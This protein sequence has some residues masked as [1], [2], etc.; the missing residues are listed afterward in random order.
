MYEALCW[1]ALLE[2]AGKQKTCLFNWF[3]KY[4]QP[5]NCMLFYWYT[6]T[7]EVRFHRSNPFWTLRKKK[8]IETRRWV[9]NTWLLWG[10]H[11]Y[12]YSQVSA[13]QYLVFSILEKKK[14]KSETSLYPLLCTK[15]IP[16]VM[17]GTSKVGKMLYW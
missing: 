3:C 1:C 8:K 16:A 6:L 2:T 14:T 5:P 15:N 9:H 10:R 17:H 4:F 7:P 12:S 11:C 13:K